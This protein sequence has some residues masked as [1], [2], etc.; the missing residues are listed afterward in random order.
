[1]KEVDVNRLDRH[2]DRVM[3]RLED[4]N[5]SISEV[6]DFLSRKRN[7]EQCKC[8]EEDMKVNTSSV[9]FTPA[10]ALGCRMSKDEDVCYSRELLEDFAQAIYQVLS[11][12]LRYDFK[13]KNKDYEEGFYD[14]ADRAVQYYE[15]F[16]DSVGVK[17]SVEDLEFN[18][19]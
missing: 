8:K 9:L 6:D 17:I 2:I 10:D 3:R 18:D 5:L 19:D 7:I 4:V 16:C 13:S 11:R 1:M 15:R 14:G 12:S